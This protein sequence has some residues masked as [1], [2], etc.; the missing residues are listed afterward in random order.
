MAT[1][2][3]VKRNKLPR[4]RAPLCALVIGG[5]TCWLVKIYLS[6]MRPGVWDQRRF[7]EL[8]ASPSPGSRR[9]YE[10]MFYFLSGNDLKR[11]R[12]WDLFVRFCEVGKID[13]DPAG[14]EMLDPPWPDLR[15]DTFGCPHYF[16][17]GEVVQENWVKAEARK[18]KKP[19]DD[20]PLPLTAVWSP[21]ESI[22]QK[23]VRKRY[24]PQATPLSLLLYWQRNAPRWKVI[25]SFV[26][27]RE[28]QIRANFQKSV[29]DHLWLFMG[30][31]SR[32]AFWLSK[33]NIIV[34]LG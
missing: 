2:R 30:Y 26:K 18:E 20:S 4:T 6:T 24:D 33:K 7:A 3:Q 15:A 17:L 5:P 25:E 1:T 32:I 27:E 10:A 34:H 8:R 11:A 16:E 28:P 31:E 22:I 14:V 23:K 19:I 12:E 21:L 29:F 9:A 13:V